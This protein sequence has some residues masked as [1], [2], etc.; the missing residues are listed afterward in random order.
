MWSPPF[1]N[2]I[3][4]SQQYSQ[5]TRTSPQLLMQSEMKD[6]GG[7]VRRHGRATEGASQG[8]LLVSAAGC[9]SLSHAPVPSCFFTNTHQL[10]RRCAERTST[11]IR[12]LLQ[13][14]TDHGNASESPTTPRCPLW[15]TT[16][17]GVEVAHPRHSHP[18]RKLKPQREG[19]SDVGC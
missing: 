14:S 3:E 6:G 12:R 1:R 19:H 16:R 2:E 15:I 11:T 8:P 17:P 9:L 18:R 13:R 4:T 10:T 5:Q 7:T